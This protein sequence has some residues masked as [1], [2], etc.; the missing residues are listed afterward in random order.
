LTARGEGFAES[1]GT[2]FS[3]PLVAGFAACAWQANPEY[4]NM[5]L[6]R[7]LEKS[8]ELYPY[9]DYAHG[10]GVPQADYFV[11]KE[12]KEIPDLIDISSDNF[13]L[14]VKV[15]LEQEVAGKF[16]K[17]LLFYNFREQDDVL[18]EYAVVQVNEENALRFKLN[19]IKPG[20]TLNFWFRNSYTSY[21]IEE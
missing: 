3:S 5:E 4:S 14:V 11:D 9:Y 13:E 15:D 2:S 20:T 6:F 7:E 19:D 18:K 8:G 16:D 10:Y 12:S 21:K 17:N 1:D